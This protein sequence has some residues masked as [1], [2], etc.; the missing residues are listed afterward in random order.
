MPTKKKTKKKKK[1]TSKKKTVKRD[2]IPTKKS[3]L[4]IIGGE[5][6]TQDVLTP[7]MHSISTTSITERI[8][9]EPLSSKDT[10]YDSA[11]DTLTDTYYDWDTDKKIYVRRG[12]KKAEGSVELNK[13]FSPEDH[14]KWDSIAKDNSATLVQLLEH[15]TELGEFP[16]FVVEEEKPMVFG[17]GIES[18]V[19]PTDE[20]I[21]KK[22]KFLN[23]TD[24]EC[25]ELIAEEES[26]EQPS[27]YPIKNRFKDDKKGFNTAKRNVHNARDQV[28][29]TKEKPSDGVFKIHQDRPF[30]KIDSVIFQKP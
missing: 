17:M 6:E 1:K 10:V 26:A 16:S 13:D 12:D 5:H 25:L 29:P 21:H 18:I 24:E 8:A 11:Y 2:S 28:E 27:E 23:T 15:K 7:P 30:N 4:F 9:Q 22:D 3:D 14:Q 20:I 19:E